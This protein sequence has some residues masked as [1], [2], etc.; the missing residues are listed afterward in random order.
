MCDFCCFSLPLPF[1]EALLWLSWRLA[2]VPYSDFFVGTVYFKTQ[3]HSVLCASAC[4]LGSIHPL[5]RASTLLTSP[6]QE[7]TGECN[8]PQ[9]LFC[10]LNPPSQPSEMFRCSYHLPVSWSHV[11]SSEDLVS[12][13]EELLAFGAEGGIYSTI[14]AA[15]CTCDAYSKDRWKQL[16]YWHSI[17]VLVFEVHR[18]RRTRWA[19]MTEEN[20]PCPE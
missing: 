4:C 8:P 9:S 15:T 20:Q 2:D 16:P 3:I 10:S 12:Q 1:G 13:T 5:T 14:E 17:I 11:V 19:V 18:M 7:M 6:S